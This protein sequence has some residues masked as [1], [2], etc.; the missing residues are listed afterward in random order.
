MADP[1]LDYGDPDTDAMTGGDATLVIEPGA[2]SEA[3][4]SG[5]APTQDLE[6]NPHIAPQEVYAD[7]DEQMQDAGENGGFGPRIGKNRFYALPPEE[8][9]KAGITRATPTG[10]TEEIS[11]YEGEFALL[12][13][14]QHAGL[15]G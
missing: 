7:D 11:T 6:L 14:T 10:E 13:L 4:H 15:F 5:F 1:I 9:A 12:A 2:A 3:A 8:A